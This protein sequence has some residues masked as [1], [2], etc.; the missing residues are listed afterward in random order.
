MPR[1]IRAR[2]LSWYAVV[3][4]LVAGTFAAVLHQRLW[5][6]TLGRVD[7]LLRISAS[8][9]CED[10]ADEPGRWREEW[11]LDSLAKGPPFPYAAVWDAEGRL[12]FRSS[13]EAPPDPPPGPLARTRGELREV[14]LSG[15]Q[16]TRVLVG[17]SLGPERREMARFLRVLLGAGALALGVALAG[18]WL[19]VG[20]VVAPIERMTRTAASISASDSSRRIDVGRTERELGELARTLNG[21]FDRL[22][23][24]FARQTRFTADASHE[25]R[26]PLAVVLAQLE[27]ALRKERSAAEY[28]E[29]LATCLD[30]ARRMKGVVEGLLTLARA[31]AGEAPLERQAVDLGAVVGETAAMLAPL[32]AEKGVSLA[33]DG[34]R[35]EATGDRNLLRQMATN[36]LANAVAYNRPGGS[37]QASLRTEGGT[38]VLEVRDTGIGISA[39]DLPHVFDRFYR[40][41]KA[42]SR[43]MGG[44]GLGLA[45]TKWIVEAHGGTIGLESRVGEGTTVRVRLPRAP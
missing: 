1:S 21:A 34:G 45:I 4:V 19:L 6:A 26:T 8:G 22:S 12:L 35:A 5:S 20:R 28:R 15:P 32:A 40:A 18:G 24:A 43:E 17:R 41:D 42:R 3:L 27:L 25:L 38:A 29:T 23:E 14:A 11:A 31:D 33:F 7:D 16:G 36:L 44:S 30:A 37:V 2:L 10:L 13:G 9:V 39:E